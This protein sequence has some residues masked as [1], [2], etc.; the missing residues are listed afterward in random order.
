[1]ASDEVIRKF[2]ANPESKLPIR[3]GKTESNRRG[4]GKQS[5]SSSKLRQELGRKEA[6]GSGDAR[7]GSGRKSSLE[8]KT[9]IARGRRPRQQSDKQA[10]RSAFLSGIKAERIHHQL[11]TE[12][13]A[14]CERCPSSWSTF[15]SAKGHLDLHHTE[16]RSRGAGFRD[17]NMG[18]DAPRLL[19][20]LCRECHREQ[21]RNEPEWSSGKE[22]G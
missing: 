7:K 2:L 1:M 6:F 3:E 15:A 19:E 5:P 8:R 21:E 22:A 11:L 13:R 9:P 14:S 20:M 18:V 10:I 12:G 17:G 4:E 16:K